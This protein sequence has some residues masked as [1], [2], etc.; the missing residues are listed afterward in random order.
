M[1]VV[2]L[3]SHTQIAFERCCLM[4][5]IVKP[6]VRIINVYYKAYKIDRRQIVT[7]QDCG[8]LYRSIGVFVG[9]T[10]MTV[11]RM[12][13]LWVKEVHLNYPSP[14]T[15]CKIDILLGWP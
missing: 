11:C 9:Q 6:H 1:I 15:S 14:V 5:C 13:N 7:C 8:L 2:Y 4:K 12:W 3:V 10:P